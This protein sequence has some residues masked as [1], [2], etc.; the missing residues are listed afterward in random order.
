MYVASRS[1]STLDVAVDL[2]L[3]P[4][5]PLRLCQRNALRLEYANTV[6]LSELLDMA[7]PA[8]ALFWHDST[9]SDGA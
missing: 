3:H 8:S 4:T 9:R 2:A 6:L 5:P 7:Y 1:F